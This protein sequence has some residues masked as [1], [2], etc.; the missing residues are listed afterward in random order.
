MAD[1]DEK[2]YWEEPIIFTGAKQGSTSIY[3][4]GESVGGILIDEA[5]K[6][7][8]YSPEEWRHKEIMDKLDKLIQLLTNK[9]PSI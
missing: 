3:M 1:K 5:G 7:T 6:E 8:H 4:R 2:A 9:K